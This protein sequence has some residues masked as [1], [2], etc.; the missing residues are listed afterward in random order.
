MKYKLLAYL[1][2]AFTINRFK[3]A[4]SQF[5]NKYKIKIVLNVKLSLV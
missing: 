2:Q 3:K 4:K 5:K 1:F